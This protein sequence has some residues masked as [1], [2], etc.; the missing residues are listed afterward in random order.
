M[1]RSLTLEVLLDV[2][3]KYNLAIWPMQVVGYVLGLTALYLVIRKKGFHELWVGLILSFLWVWTGIVFFILYF[4]PVYLPACIFGGFFVVQALFFLIHPFAPRPPHGD[5]GRA[6]KVI[7]MCFVVYAM[8]GY[9]LA[10][11]LLGHI[12]PWAPVFGLTPCPLVVFTFGLFL[13]S[14]RKLPWWM[15]PVPVL[16][17]I[18]G[19]VPVSLGVLEDIGLMVAGVLGTSLIIYRDRDTSD[20]KSLSPT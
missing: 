3:E 12:Y 16:W 19:I 13:L 20:L 2:F 5:K 18:G 1:G 7:G 4:G 14:D 10:S 8:I 15:L 17:A 9:P 11:I 6:N